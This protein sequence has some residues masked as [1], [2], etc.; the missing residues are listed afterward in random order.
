MASRFRKETDLQN[1]R[2]RA[3]KGLSLFGARSGDGK[4]FFVEVKIGKGRPSKD[5]VKFLE[6]ANEHKVLNGVAWNLEQAIEI[7]EGKRTI[8]D[9]EEE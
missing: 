4:L 2:T 6:S 5:Q 8:N 7:V 9:L 1:E 3:R